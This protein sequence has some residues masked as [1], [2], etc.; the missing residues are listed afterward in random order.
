MRAVYKLE[1]TARSVAAA[2]IWLDWDPHLLRQ[3]PILL[4]SAT[5]TELVTLR[6]SLHRQL[7][8][9]HDQVNRL[10][11]VAISQLARM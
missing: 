2:T 4:V 8:Q 6:H 7:H 10:K 9:T 5:N 11:S 3:N 1:R